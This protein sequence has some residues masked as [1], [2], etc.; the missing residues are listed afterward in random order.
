MAHFLPYELLI[1]QNFFLNIVVYPNAIFCPNHGKKNLNNTII[2]HK[3]Q[4]KPR[5]D[6]TH[7]SSTPWIPRV[8]HRAH[9]QE[10]CGKS[11]WSSILRMKIWEDRYC[12]FIHILHAWNYPSYHSAKYKMHYVVFFFMD[13]AAMALIQPINLAYNFSWYGMASSAFK[14]AWYV[15]SVLLLYNYILIR[16]WAPNLFLLIFYLI[17]K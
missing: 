17:E 16:K 5:Q 7:T 15:F 13:Q 3:W 8:G 6:C 14:S 1:W 2:S 4:L 10:E 9:D 11:A 12:S